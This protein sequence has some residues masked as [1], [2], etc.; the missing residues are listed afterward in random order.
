MS[1]FPLGQKEQMSKTH[2]LVSF[3]R[4]VK[5]DDAFYNIKLLM[6]LRITNVKPIL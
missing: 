1:L 5:H 2:M 4:Q 3:T 6:R